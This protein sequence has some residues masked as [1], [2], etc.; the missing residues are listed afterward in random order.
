MA[1][2]IL[3]GGRLKLDDVIDPKAG[4]IFYPKIGQKISKGELIA[5]IFTDK[6]N[7]IENAK[8]KIINSITISSKK[9]KPVSLVKTII[10]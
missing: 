10:K 2:L 4:I 3:G 6:K 5:E 9:C 7:M 1:S 8:T